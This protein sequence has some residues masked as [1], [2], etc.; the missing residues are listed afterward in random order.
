M[1]AQLATP[2][3]TR[4]RAEGTD[5]ALEFARTLEVEVEEGRQESLEARGDD[6]SNDERQE[7]ASLRASAETR[8]AL[9]DAGLEA[10]D[11]APAPT[12]PLANGT[13]GPPLLTADAI[14]EHAERQG[15]AKGGDGNGESDW[16]DFASDE[17][18]EAAQ[19]AGLTPADF[20]GHDASGATGYTK[21]D[22]EAA[23]KR[24]EG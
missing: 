4:L 14:R 12:A 20:E 11:V 2:T 6:L 16:S 15:K 13:Q 21:A 22:V 8:Q 23:V 17:A 18:A 5:E 24:K 7:L 3:L 1:L 10:K 19:K 9:E